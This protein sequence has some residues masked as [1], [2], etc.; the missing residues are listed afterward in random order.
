MIIASYTKHT[1]TAA[2]DSCCR[3][4]LGV[5]IKSGDTSCHRD[6]FL[7]L[8]PSLGKGGRNGM[9]TEGWQEISTSNHP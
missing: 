2:Q 9:V 1:H 5:V 7:L 6:F 4:E 3:C 8:P